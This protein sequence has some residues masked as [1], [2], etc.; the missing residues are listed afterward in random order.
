MTG[1]LAYWGKR[2]GGKGS[3]GRWEDEVMVKERGRGV[4]DLSRCD[5]CESFHG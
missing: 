2:G 1:T 4:T 5:S 3:A